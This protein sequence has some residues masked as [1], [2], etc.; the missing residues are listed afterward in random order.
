M[1]AEL[2]LSEEEESNRDLA[3][4]TEPSPSKR[5]KFMGACKYR[6]SFSREWT[7]TWP[8]VSSVPGNPHMFTCNVCR[9]TL[10]CAHQG[11]ADVKD[12]VATQS[13]KKLA[14]VLANQPKLSFPSS[15]PLKNRVSSELFSIRG[16]KM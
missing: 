11:I 16:H 7:K 12:H 14:K 8:F 10:S 1:D 9:K 6:S 15:D 5:T 13:H 4:G 3:S 2:S